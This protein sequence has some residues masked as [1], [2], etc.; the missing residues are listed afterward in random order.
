MMPF[1]PI[2]QVA[3]FDEALEKA[4]Q[5][6]NNNNHTS[7]VHTR[8]LDRVAYLRRTIKTTVCIVNGPCTAAIGVGGDGEA[9]FAVAT[10]TG[11]GVLNAMHFTRNTRLALG[12]SL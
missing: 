7:M 6:E 5:F 12:Y 3:S 10:P 11:E 1:I 9:S 4:I 8:R 2:V